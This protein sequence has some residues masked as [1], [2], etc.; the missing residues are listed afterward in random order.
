MRYTTI[1]SGIGN[2]E[3]GIGNRESGIG[4]RTSDVGR[5]TS[6]YF[7]VFSNSSYRTTLAVT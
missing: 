2:R 1:S 4:L 3:S 6:R 7:S 5:R